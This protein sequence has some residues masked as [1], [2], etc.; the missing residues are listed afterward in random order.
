MSRHAG[1]TWLAD[2]ARSAET[3]RPLDA[4]P[5]SPIERQTTHLQRDQRERVIGAGTTA[6]SAAPVATATYR[7]GG[8]GASQDDGRRGPRTASSGSVSD[9]ANSRIRHASNPDLK[10]FGA[11]LERFVRRRLAAFRIECLPD[12]ESL[13]SDDRM[14][15]VIVRS[16]RLPRRRGPA[17]HRR[18]R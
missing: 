8:C 3:T 2:P 12:A 6:A 7:A 13:R 9:R 15:Q 18:P 1:P 5:D 14:P 17:T 10:G 16:T 4:R 11:L